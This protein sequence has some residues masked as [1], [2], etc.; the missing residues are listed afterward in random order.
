MEKV[1][2]SNIPIK[3]WVPSDELEIG[4]LKQASNLSKLPF[5]FK[6]IAL[7]PDC[8]LGYGMPIGGV[9]ATKDVII[10]NA[11]GVDI[12]CGVAVCR[13]NIQDISHDQIKN[14]FTEIRKLIPLGKN[15]HKKEQHHLL[16]PCID[17]LFEDSIVLSNYEAAKKQIGTLGG[18]NHF[19]E[20][21]KGSDGYIYIMI[22]S[23]SRNVGFK[24]ANY[25]NKIARELNKKWFSSGDPKHDLAFLPIVSQ[26]GQDYLTE[27]E[28]CVEF[29]ESNRG[30]M[31]ELCLLAIGEFF[32]SDDFSTSPIDVAHNYVAI[33]NH[34]GKNVLVHRK[35]ATKAYAGEI[36][37]IPGSQGTSSF[38][39][40]G[41]GNEMS[42]KSCSHGAGRL[43][44]RTKA[45]TD[46]N[47]AVEVKK[48][49]DLGIVHGLKSKNNLDEASSAY[50]NIHDVMKNQEDLVDVMVELK[51]LGVIKG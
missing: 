31:M 25:Y 20:I 12:G 49:D 41:K 21:Q 15:H 22:H 19:I 26:E 3:S 16:V 24:V 45:K 29:A 27:M 30:Y 37:L 47:L 43:M 40:R 46:L 9:L 36:G 33:E 42:F 14:V 18:G 28:W 11:V 50:K 48:M 32:L 8:H 23:G 39:V 4:A 51:P 35:G 10:P 38:I 7:M 6:H 5:A 1:Y 2:D 34:F 17:H 44:S 13:L